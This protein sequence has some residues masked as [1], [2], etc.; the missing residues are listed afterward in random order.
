M[1]P[2]ERSHSLSW[3]DTFF[4]YLERDGQPINIASCCEFEGKITRQA[5]A[6]FVKSKLHLI[7]RYKQR[8]VFP[9]FNLGLPTWELDPDFD[10]KN[11]VH[12]VLLKHG[13][14]ADLKAETA[15][16]VSSTLDRNRPLWD[17][18]L[19]RGLQGNRTGVIIRIH[20]C[21]ADGVSGVGIMNV[22][23]DSSPNPEK[24]A[25]VPART[26]HPHPTDSLAILL[27]QMLKSYQSFMQGALTAQNELLNIAREVLGTVTNGRTEDV[28]RLVPELATPA[29][30]LPFNKVCRGPQQIAWGELPLTDIKTIRERFG[31]TVNDVVLTVITSTVRRYALRHGVKVRGRHLRLV[32]PVNVR[33]DGDVTELGNRITFLPVNV[34]LDISDPSALMSRISER[35]TF[36]RGIGVPEIIGMFGLLVSKVPLPIQAILVPVLTHL[37]LSLANMICTNVPGPQV[38]LYLLGHKL[39]RCYPY[40]PIG[41]ELGVNVAILSYNGVAYVGFGGDVFATPD[42]ERFEYMLRESFSELCEA[43]AKSEPSASAEAAQTDAPEK[44]AR[45]TVQMRTIPTAPAE[46]KLRPAKQNK[47]KPAAQS[48]PRS[49]VRSKAPVKKAVPFPRSAEPAESNPEL[50]VEVLAATGD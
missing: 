17:I 9:A 48:Q 6:K 8:A 45:R 44:P 18:T 12:E 1:S 11:H 20:H 35:V 46:P 30:R 40:V 38:P 28:I 36:L 47:K 3:G 34:P 43:A 27:D 10:I 4:L 50:P 2:S 24:P 13:T 15:K 49:K 5:C 31:G 23:L 37:P 7:P 29:E 32:V 25:N 14:E 41:G 26:D 42:I 21:L 19:V 33:G 22:L 16:V 39:L